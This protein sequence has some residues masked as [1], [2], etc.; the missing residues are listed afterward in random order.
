VV[1]VS[2]HAGV[3]GAEGYL[4]RLLRRLPPEWRGSVIF[5]GEGPA[6][7]R[8]EAAGIDVIVLPRGR[9][10][11]MLLGLGQLRRTLA[12]LD[13]TVV[14]A[15]GVIAAM[16]TAIALLF[17]R[18]PIV[19]LKVDFSRDGILNNLIALRCRLVVGISRVVTSTLRGPLRRRARVVHCGLPAYDFDRTEARRRVLELTGWSEETE[20]VLV[21]GRLAEGKGQI[22][23]IEA[24]P[25]ILAARP[26][27]RFL[28]LGAHDPFHPDYAERVAERARALGVEERI[29]VSDVPHDG[30]DP[31]YEAVRVTAGSDVVVVPS[32]REEGSGW[33]EGFGLVGA[34]AFAVGTPVVAY[35]N[36]SLQEVLGDCARMADEGDREALAA[37]VIEI[38]SN[39]DV[40]NEMSSCGR[41]LA[42]ERYVMERAVEGMKAC[43]LEAVGGRH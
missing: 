32:V 19:W 37:H 1:F 8:L 24:A 21:S 40:R 12:G 13:P 5:L 9:R 29:V 26:D 16:N 34:E 38:L 4:D 27:A 18:V 3:G 2:A 43:Y 28:L 11:R 10:W 30:E 14:H 25:A 22:E 20:I 31:A 39:A 15:H 7:R 23:L 41:R 36:G 6:P 33:Q 42:A 35:R 17:R